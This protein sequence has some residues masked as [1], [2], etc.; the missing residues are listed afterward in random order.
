M[1]SS[2]PS[3][4][5]SNAS[6]ENETSTNPSSPMQEPE[7]DPTDGGL[8]KFKQGKLPW[9]QPSWLFL[10]AGVHVLT[11]LLEIAVIVMTVY[12][13][14]YAQ[15]K[16]FQATLQVD[17]DPTDSIATD[18]EGW[19]S[20]AAVDLCEFI[21]CQTS[22]ITMSI[23]RVRNITR[24]RTGI[25]L[26]KGIEQVSMVVYNPKVWG[27]PAL[28][29]QYRNL[30]VVFKNPQADIYSPP[31]GRFTSGGAGTLLMTPGREDPFSPAFNFVVVA[32]WIVGKLQKA[33]R[34]RAY[35]R[36]YGKSTVD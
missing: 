17:F 18:P 1:S 30:E 21:Q 33:D 32:I 34:E 24:S 4:P 9:A 10:N 7:L 28:S 5:K 3:S 12:W 20:A 27:L 31:Y 8:R 11:M 13:G 6:T 15:N 22:T 2:H 19:I 36:I 26:L 14:A 16:S 23:L 25:V 29:T 35:I